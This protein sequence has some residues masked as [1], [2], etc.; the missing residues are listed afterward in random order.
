MTGGTSSRSAATENCRNGDR[1]VGEKISRVATRTLEIY[2]EVWTEKL[3]RSVGLLPRNNSWAIKGSCCHRY[4]NISWLATVVT[5]SKEK[6]KRLVWNNILAMQKWKPFLTVDWQVFALDNGLSHWA[7]ILRAASFKKISLAVNGSVLNGSTFQPKLAFHVQLLKLQLDAFQAVLLLDS[8]LNLNSS[9]FDADLFVDR[10][11]CAFEGGWPLVSQPPVAHRW[12]SQSFWPMNYKG[13]WSTSCVKH[14]LSKGISKTGRVA[15]LHVQGLEVAYVEA[16]VAVLDKSFFFWLVT[17]VG[18]ELAHVQQSR[19]S[20][21]GID[22]IWCRAARYYATSVLKSKE[23]CA[24]AVLPVPML[25]MDTRTIKKDGRFISAG[26][27]VRKFAS[28]RWPQWWLP[29]RVARLYK[30]TSAHVEESQR[31]SKDR[32]M[33]TTFSSRKLGEPCDT[34]LKSSRNSTRSKLIRTELDR[35]VFP[36]FQV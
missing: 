9:L 34:H 20:D 6:A 2:M 8:D 32:H 17:N 12:P 24:C 16:Q 23:R 30:L 3:S 36:E 27:A 35:I 33:V 29:S 28:S 4:R 26:N 22:Q 18:N 13:E 25:H 19:G 31:L 10:W 15:D 21:W 1:R 7:D 11:L 14:C 5:A